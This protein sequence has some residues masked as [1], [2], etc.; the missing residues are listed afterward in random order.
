MAAQRERNA[1]DVRLHPRGH[2][3]GAGVT[4]GP[5]RP[6]IPAANPT[7]EP[8]VGCAV[9][10]VQRPVPPLAPAAPAAP[11]RSPARRNRA[12]AVTKTT[13]SVTT[14]GTPPRMATVPAPA[15][16]S[17]QLDIPLARLR[18]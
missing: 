15:P 12:S 17:F 2:G 11:A 6:A 3:P 18:R 4:Q 1:F 5:R 16:V 8:G 10:R 14:A 9:K 7:V 13:V